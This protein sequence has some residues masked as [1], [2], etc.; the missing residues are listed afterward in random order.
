MSTR[1]WAEKGKE[2]EA[3][4]KE[5]RCK[6]VKLLGFVIKGI[7]LAGVRSSGTDYDLLCTMRFACGATLVVVKRML[8]SGISK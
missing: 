8:I 5:D 2:S 4:S 6:D 1:G 7:I 3:K